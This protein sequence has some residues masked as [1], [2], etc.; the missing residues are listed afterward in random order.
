MKRIAFIGLSV[1]ISVFAFSSRA[2]V[3]VSGKILEKSTKEP[4]EYAN[5]IL[6]SLPDSS[7]VAGA[8]SGEEGVFLFEKV[9]SGTYLLKVS[10]VG[11]ENHL[12]AFDVATEAIVL[13]DIEMIE[14][15]TLQ[16]VVVTSRTAPFKASTNGGIVANVSTTLLSSVGT[17]HDVLQRIPGIISENGKIT[18]FGRG[19]PIVY[20]NNRKVRDLSELERLESSEISTVELITNPGAKYD[21]EGKAILLIKTKN[22]VNG[23]ATQLTERIRQGKHLGDNE[24]L[25]LSYT[26]D[27]LNVFATYYHN[28]NK[29]HNTET[30]RLILK[31]NDEEWIHGT[32][33]PDSWFSNNT[34]QVSTGFDYSVNKK[35][36]LG[37]QYQY[38]RRIHHEDVPISTTT[39]FNNAPYE[40]SAA[41]SYSDSKNHQHLLNAFYN[42][43]FSEFFSSR[44]DFDYLKHH[45]YSEQQSDEEINSTDSRNVVIYNQTDYNLYAGKLTNSWKTDV[46]LLEFGGEYNTI[47][48]NG[49]VHSSGYTDNS[50]FT[51]TEN[52]VAG[53]VSYSRNIAAVNLVTG[54]RYEYTSEHFTQGNDNKPFIERHYSDWY[55]NITISGRLKNM[56]LSLAFNK[57]TQRP[58][59]S[60]LNGNVVYLNRFVFQKGNPYLSKENIYNIN[61][62]AIL[63]PFLFSLDYT[64]SKSPIIATLR[65]QE[66]STNAILST[67]ENF[68]KNQT[69]SAILSFNHTIGFWQP[70]YTIGYIKPLF[71]AIYDGQELSFDRPFGIFNAYNDFTLPAGFVL[72]LNFRYRSPAM[73]YFMEGKESKQLDMVI[74]KSFFN[75]SLR[76]NLSVFDIF[77]WNEERA[78][79]K[80]NNLYWETNKKY[81]TRYATLSITYLFNNYRKKYRGNNAA[82]E[83]LDRF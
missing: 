77:D 16:E 80:F 63:K 19:A 59:F 66:N 3:P 64:H 79:I 20:L 71:K 48:G 21:A 5:I 37:A 28:Y 67:Y 23:F 8:V 74:R 14:S 54:L 56:D 57:R 46:G 72:S 7:F 38:Y 6:L 42:A 47:K 51:N 34:Q 9:N 39:D 45:D 78:N 17:A 29:Q 1:L 55:P 40:T 30:D 68:P 76:F 50:D 52:K 10:Y 2:S 58:S 36:A 18:V 24:N 32:Y 4:L 70:N 35:H 62:Q 41:Q 65:E 43:D 44:L 22:R 73:Q 27:R 33:L 13:K 60:Q 49:Y 61:F 75:N 82:K 83:D 81:E 12:L 31:N 15:N 69:I 11:F 25:S 53:F 26:K